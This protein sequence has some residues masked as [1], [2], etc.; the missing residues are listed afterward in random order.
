MREAATHLRIVKWSSGLRWLPWVALVLM[1]TLAC[2]ESGTKPKP[3]AD[4][5]LSDSE[6]D[7]SEVTPETLVVNSVAPN[8]GP[9]EGGTAVVISGRN[10]AEGATVA[11]GAASATS[12][13]FVSSSQL[14]ATTPAASAAGAVDVSVTNPGGEK[15]TKSGA[16]TYREPV[17]DA[18]D[19][20]SVHFPSVVSMEPGSTTPLIFGRAWEGGCTE[21][22]SRCAQLSAELGYGAAGSDPSVNPDSFQWVSATYNEAHV[23]DDNDEYMATLTV[24][25][26]GSYGYAYRMKLGTGP[27]TYCDL[28]DS[29]DGFQASSL[30]Q[31][32][33]AENV[34]NVAWC[35]LHYPAATK[36]APGNQS[37]PIFGR[38]WAGGCTD[39]EGRC[40]ELGGQLGYGPLGANPQTD[41]QAFTWVDATYNEAHIDDDNDEYMASLTLNEAGEYAYAYRFTADEGENWLYCDLGAGSDDG[42]QTSELGLLTVAEDVVSIGWCALRFPEVI[43]VEPDELS[44]LIFGRVYAQGCTEMGAHCEAIEGQVGYGPHGTLPDET[45]TWKDAEFNAAH[46][47]DD[48]DEYM[49]TWSF[50]TKGKYSYAYRF[51]A[52]GRASWSYCDLGPEGS[53]DGIQAEALGELNV[54]SGIAWCE[55]VFPKATGTMPDV[56][57]EPIFAQ[58]LIP[59][60][61]GNTGAACP[62]VQAQ[63]GW[64]VES[65]ELDAYTFVDASYNALHAGDLHDEYSAQLS[66]ASEGDYRYVARFAYDGGDWV[67]CDGLGENGFQSE[68]AGALHVGARTID[69]CNIQ[70]PPTLTAAVGVESELVYGQVLVTGCTDSAAYC[71]GLRAEL[72]YGVSGDDPSTNPGVFEWTSATVNLGH[73]GSNNNEYTATLTP[74]Q[75]GG[76]NYVYRFS[77]DAGASWTY[78]DTGGSP[79]DVAEMGVL[80]VE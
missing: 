33:V 27:W 47:D 39:G 55:L 26:A 51:T 64:G 37:E 31:L 50:P 70:W 4:V 49:T 40:N 60:C 23:D 45:W 44:E 76:F 46:S 73:S 59:G 1:A 9:V 36:V 21:G 66:V 14:K 28:A 20:C 24:A 7:E 53:G 35:S 72:G 16:F 29:P 17:V 58:L 34:V 11:F 57:S 67:Y 25:N 56:P 62:N 18:V 8:A 80:T 54:G 22:G 38:V 52:D 65:D 32:T 5:E 69:W 63:L 68:E 41:P 74:A 13:E 75:V 42:V 61:T 2:E 30:G 71:G 15:A 12:V 43:N 19:W 78:C 10:F 6:F 3:D 77:G 48:E 79:F